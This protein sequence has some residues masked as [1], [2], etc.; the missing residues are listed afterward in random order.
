[1]RLVAIPRTPVGCSESLRDAH[2]RVERGQIRE[3]IERREHEDTP[4]AALRLSE[5]GRAV[6]VEKRDRV[7]RGV[8]RAEQGPVDGAIQDDR[9]GAQRRERVPIQAARWDDIDA[10]GPALQDGSQRR[11]ATRTR[12][13]G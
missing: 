9:N 10:G 12:G 1:M 3:G 5:S 7:R 11:R 6:R 8:A 2:H 4:G 13:R